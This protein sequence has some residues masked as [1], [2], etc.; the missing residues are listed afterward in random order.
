MGSLSSSQ[1]Q[2]VILNAK[3]NV[4]VEAGKKRKRSM[5]EDDLLKTLQNKIKHGKRDMKDFDQ[6][7]MI[8]MPGK[9]DT[10]RKRLRR[11]KRSEEQVA[12]ENADA[13][14]GMVAHRAGGISDARRVG[15][16]AGR[17]SK[18]TSRTFSCTQPSSS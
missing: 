6:R 14:V 15:V 13:R 17:K 11:M 7:L 5:E 3:K 1:R 9:S 10:E 8:K 2:F 12:K 4:L 18:L 16:R